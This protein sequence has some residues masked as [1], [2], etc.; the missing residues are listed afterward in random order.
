[1]YHQIVSIK[2]LAK[3]CS[4]NECTLGAIHERRLLKGGGRRVKNVGIYL[5]KRRQRWREGVIK[6]EK[7]ADIVYGWPLTVL[8]NQILSFSDSQDYKKIMHATRE[9]FW[10]FCELSSGNYFDFFQCSLTDCN[11][12]PSFSFSSERILVK[13]SCLCRGAKAGKAPKAWALPRFWVSIRSYKKQPVKKFWGRILGLAWLNFT[14]APLLCVRDIFS[15]NS[16]MTFIVETTWY[17]NFIA[18][19][20]LYIPSTYSKH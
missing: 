15:V 16:T 12:F 4:K 5:V 10:P 20:K 17:L 11:R 2:D 8:I 18:V 9:K 1:M 13:M 6:S 3:H 14:V 19:T 7:W